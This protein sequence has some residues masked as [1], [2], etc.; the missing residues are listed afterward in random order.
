MP[1]QRNQ[2][3]EYRSTRPAFEVVGQPDDIIRLHS[4]EIPTAETR[5]IGDN[6][7]RYA[8]A[9]L[10]SLI[11]RYYVTIP[12][13]E[14]VDVLGK[15]LN[16]VTDRVVMLSLFYEAGPL[17]ASNRLQNITTVPPWNVW[18]WDVK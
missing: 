12:R 10:D 15:I 4:S 1:L 9:D 2:D 14:R 8:N 18:A 16:H 11:E 7:P 3:R 17:L 5:Y 6:R 13:A